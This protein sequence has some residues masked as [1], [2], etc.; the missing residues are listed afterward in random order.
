MKK[1][2]RKIIYNIKIM[3]IEYRI[4]TYNDSYLKELWKDNWFLNCINDNKMYWSKEIKQTRKQKEAIK[5]PQYLEFKLLYP[6]SDWITSDRVIK[7]VN[8]LYDKWKFQELM[9]WVQ[10]YVKFVK[11]NNLIK[12][13]ILN[14]ATFLNNNR[15][16]DEFSII[17]TKIGASD[18]WMNTYFENLEPNI[19]DKVLEKKREWCRKYPN[20][21]FTKWVLEIMIKWAITGNTE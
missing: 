5:T 7:M 20:K 8:D 4:T 17:D 14:P 15:W 11:V 10:D 16:Q 1:S 9:K 6:K 12:K 21:E 19:I 18:S 2:Y 3:T 13:F